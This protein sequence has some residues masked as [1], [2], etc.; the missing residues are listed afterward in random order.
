MIIIKLILV[1]NRLLIGSY[2]TGGATEKKKSLFRHESSPC[3]N[4]A[5]MKGLS[6]NNTFLYS[7]A[8]QQLGVIQRRK[9]F[10]GNNSRIEGG[11]T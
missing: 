10:E 5:L 2:H 7:R 8:F 1:L 3:I 4:A 11:C 9:I 6:M